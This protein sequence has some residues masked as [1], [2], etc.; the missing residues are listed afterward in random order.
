MDYDL[1]LVIGIVLLVFTIPAIVSSISDRRAPRLPALVLM[2]GAVLVT[3]ALTQRP[4]GY[5]FD[6]IVA[7][8]A[9]VVGR[10]F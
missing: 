9:S 1:F 6:G 8:F 5:T 7:A 10:F 3:L 4:G 2:I